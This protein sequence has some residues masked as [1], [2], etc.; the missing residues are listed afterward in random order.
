MYFLVDFVTS[1][2]G[3]VHSSWRVPCAS[4]IAAQPRASPPL[5]QAKLYCCQLY[6]LWSRYARVEVEIVGPWLLSLFPLFLRKKRREVGRGSLRRSHRG[7]SGCAEE[8]HAGSKIPLS[9][10]QPAPAPAPYSVGQCPRPCA[11]SPSV[12]KMSGTTGQISLYWIIIIY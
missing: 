3:C 4:C 5:I 7:H 1:R 10:K 9:N 6:S 12:V 8:S 2:V 11:R